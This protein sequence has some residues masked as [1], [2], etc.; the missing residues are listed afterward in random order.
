MY[1]AKVR[2]YHEAL[3][4]DLVVNQLGEPRSSGCWMAVGRG[5][6]TDQGKAA[7]GAEN[8][9]QLR[10]LSIFPWE[11]QDPKMEVR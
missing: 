8:G 4:I 9:T 10:I 1:F 6:E 7:F 3:A 5:D 2:I 11:F